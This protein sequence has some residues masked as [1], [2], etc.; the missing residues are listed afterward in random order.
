VLALGAQ[1]VP[2]GLGWSV[3]SVLTFPSLCFQAQERVLG[4]RWG[5][6]AGSLWPQREAREV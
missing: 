5:G 3:G 4:D 2:Q 1:T 6:C